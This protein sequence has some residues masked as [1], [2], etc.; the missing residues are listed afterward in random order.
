MEKSESRGLGRSFRLAGLLSVV[1]ALALAA[2]PARATI[3]YT[4]SLAQ[5]DQNLVHV[6]MTVP[7]AENPLRVKLPAWNALYQIRDFAFRVTRVHAADERGNSLPVSK[8]D[9]NTWLVA[10]RGS[11]AL[12]YFVLWDEPGPFSSEVNPSHAFLNLATI[13]FYIPSRR[14]ENVRIEFT[15]LPAG[16]RVGVALDS[17]GAGN[18]FGAQGY[19]DLVDAPVEI[20]AFEE[21]PLE[22]GAAR[23]RVLVHAAEERGGPKVWSRDRLTDVV[24]RVVSYQT[25]LMRDTP[26]RS[27]LFLYHFGLGGG[28]GSGMEHVNSTA[29][30]LDAGG[31]PAALTAHEFF[32]LWNVKRIRPQGLEP[33]NFN[34]EQPTTA[35]WFAEGVTNTYTAYTLVRTGLWS[36]DDFYSDLAAQI[37]TLQS[38]PA[39]LWQSA[40]QA[41]LDAW[42]EKY[43]LYRRGSLSIS[44]YNK[45]QLLGVL[46]DILIRHLSD[47]AASLDDLMRNLNRDFAK[48]GR[49]YRDPADLLSAA[50]NLTGT[51]HAAAL[52]EFFRRY[53]SGTDELPLQDYFSSA[54]LELRITVRV[55]A[56]FGF[57]VSTVAREGALLTLVTHVVPGSA[58]EK[59]GLRPGDEIETLNRAVFPINISEWLAG[60]K[61]GEVIHVR[62]RRGGDLREFSF[63]LGKREE[64]VYSV[65][66]DG[67]AGEKARRIRRGLLEGVT[68]AGHPAVSPVPPPPS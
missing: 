29:M 4:V 14:K 62:L 45:G 40:E 39:R 23:V 32:H 33:V 11:V 30:V 38:R 59:A 56:E 63:P 64:N 21:V 26:F 16:W 28:G 66:E 22:I 31:D 34:A 43:L 44:Y 20:G 41:S 48:Q 12:D 53:V 19:D 35:L 17:S 24:R 36:R 6:T 54:G 58:A 2:A 68:Q 10:G 51:E 15:D 3:H 25:G 57:Y 60:H 67:R 13:L 47:N 42:F 65:R 55:A 46:L 1:T 18:S 9:P 61:P 7:A 5:R 8:S 27:Y 37:E 49:F 52:E 50:K